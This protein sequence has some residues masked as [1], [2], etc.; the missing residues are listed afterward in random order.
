MTPIRSLLAAA[1]LAAPFVAPVPARAEL[2][3]PVRNLSP[4][5]IGGL[6]GMPYLDPASHP[7]SMAATASARAHNKLTPTMAVQRVAGGTASVYRGA[8]NSAKPLAPPMPPT[9]ALLDFISTGDLSQSWAA[10]DANG[11]PFIKTTG[12]GDFA[13]E[14]NA[15][16]NTSVTV[17]AGAAGREVVVRFVVPPV[18]VA[19]VTEQ[20]GPARWR[21]RLRGELLVN[22]FPAWS[23][24]AHRFTVDPSKIDNGTEIVLLEEFGNTLGF[25]SD[26][27]DGST[28]NDTSA[29]NINSQTAPKTVYLTLG[30]FTAGTVLDLSMILRANATT[31]PAVAGG[32]DH[33]CVWKSADARYF[34]SRASVS[35]DGGSGEAPRIYLLP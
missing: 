5:E 1:L 11:I 9:S 26:D 17:P 27:E 2:P 4:V 25:A 10:M 28:S 8:P 3:L 24:E 21:A 12:Y 30:R 23:T 20:D 16:W 7:F 22:G 14:A 6:S 31:V 32:T 13:A 19:G 35:I 34:C 18:S 29:Q 15:S 33:R